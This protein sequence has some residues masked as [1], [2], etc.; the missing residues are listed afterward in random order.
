VVILGVVGIVGYGAYKLVPRLLSKI[1]SNTSAQN[2][3]A[4]GGGY[5]EAD[6]GD[7][8]YG[9]EGYYQQQPSTFQSLLSTISSLFGKGG[10][11]SGSGS[12]GGLGSGS[13]GSGSNS[14]YSTGEISQSEF[15]TAIADGKSYAPDIPLIDTGAGS[16][17]ASFPT[18]S[19]SLFD[20]PGVYIDPGAS[21][22]SA[23]GDIGA[24]QQ[25]ESLPTGGGGNIN[26]P[27]VPLPDS[28]DVYSTGDTGG[29]GYSGGG[30]DYGDDGGD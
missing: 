23:T 27:A 2:T 13:G 6:S 15:A 11:S 14:G 10:G 25:I 1:G 21:I 4:G 26:L 7:G 9:D 19:P 5:T 18:D 30:G 29:T 16:Y 28:G 3:G 22:P 8:Y 20:N 17:L 24:G 12:G